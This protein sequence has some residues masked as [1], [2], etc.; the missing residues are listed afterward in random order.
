MTDK[1]RTRK[2]PINERVIAGLDDLLSFVPVSFQTTQER[3]AA[4]QYLTALVAYCK[5]PEYRKK[6]EDVSAKT[7]NWYLENTGRV[8][9]PRAIGRPKRPPKAVEEK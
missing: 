9:T 3:T 4:I 2:P 1:K 8:I 7:R 6:R 5:T